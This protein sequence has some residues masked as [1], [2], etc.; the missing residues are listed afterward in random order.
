[1]ILG[2]NVEFAAGKDHREISLQQLESVVAIGEILGARM[3]LQD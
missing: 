2:E 1:M 3:G